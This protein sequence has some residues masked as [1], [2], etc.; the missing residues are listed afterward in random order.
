MK[1]W[2]LIVYFLI[3][4]FRLKMYGTKLNLELKRYYCL[5]D[6]SEMR[7]LNGYYLC[8]KCGTMYYI[9]KDLALLSE[10]RCLNCGRKYKNRYVDEV[11]GYFY[12]YIYLNLY[13][14]HCQS[15]QLFIY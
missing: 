7:C 9:L 6:E 10:Y 8:D 11:I 1:S 12:N 4:L 2:K 5:Y 13:C 14:G 15:E 3:C